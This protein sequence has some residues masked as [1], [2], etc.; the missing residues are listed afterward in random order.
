MYSVED[1]FER[2]KEYLCLEI[3]AGHKGIK[4][5]IQVP[6]AQRPGLSL[7]GYLKSYASKRILVFGKVEVEYL[8]DLNPATRIKRLE[9]LLTE[10]T[11]AIVIARRFRPP[12]ELLLIAEK[13]A[14]PVLRTSMSTMNVLSKLILLL[15]EEF[16][17][18][19]FLP[20]DAC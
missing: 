9:P 3:I 20:W 19:M 18:S 14:I 5:P 4:R 12:K 6:E 15:N 11:P 16:A 7:S 8:R 13:N 1:L 2:H 10:K 17:P